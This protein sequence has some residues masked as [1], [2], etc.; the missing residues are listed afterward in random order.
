MFGDILVG[1]DYVIQDKG[2]MRMEMDRWYTSLGFRAIMWDNSYAWKG[3]L[4]GHE[5]SHTLACEFAHDLS[6]RITIV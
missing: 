5:D 3:M 6:F 2:S 1:Q 4:Y